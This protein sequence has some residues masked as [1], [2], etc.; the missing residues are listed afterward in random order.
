M[1]PSCFIIGEGTL[2]IECSTIL[3]QRG[4][5]IRGI[6]S[7]DPQVL[8]YCAS[9]GLRSIGSSL[10]VATILNDEPFDYLFSISNGH[11]L[12]EE[13]LNIPRLFTL[14]YHDGPLP[15]YA[16]V[17]ATFWAL[18]ND[19]KTH[20]VTWH[21]VDTGIDTGAIVK[22]KR[23]PIQSDETSISLNIK[24]YAAAVDAFR[25][26][27]DELESGKLTS[28]PQDTAGRSYYARNKRPDLILNFD[29]PAATIARM[30]RSLDFGFQSNPFGFL[31]IWA[32]NRFWLVRGA[33]AATTD[34]KQLPGTIEACFPDRLLIATRDFLLVIDDVQT[35]DGEPVSMAV[36]YEQTSLTEGQLVRLPAPELIQAINRAEMQ[37]AVHQAY[38]VDKLCQFQP[39]KLS[40]LLPTGKRDGTPPER[41]QISIPLCKPLGRRIGIESPT[42]YPLAMT[43]LLVTLARLTNQRSIGVG[44]RS[45]SS[46]RIAAETAGA[47]AEYLPLQVAF[48]WE[49]G[50]ERALYT[51]Q[52]ELVTLHNHLTFAQESLVSQTALQPLKQENDQP[53]FPILIDGN[54]PVSD[55][56]F[57]GDG[58]RISLPT[59]ENPAGQVS[60]D[61]ARWPANWVADLANRWIL[62][63]ENLVRQPSQPL[64]LVSLLT[65]DEQQRILIDWNATKTDYPTHQTV[66][67]LVEA[68]ADQRPQAEALRVGSLAL[69]YEQLNQ[70]ANQLAWHLQGQGIKPD[71]LLG[72][73]LERSADMIVS[74]LAILKVGGAYVPLDPTFPTARLAELVAETGLHHI[75]TQRAWVD[76]LP[77]QSTFIILDESRKLIARQSSCNLAISVRADQLAYVLFTSGSTGRSKGVAVPHRAIVRTVRSTNYMR[78]DETICMLGL[79]PL[80][81][82]A[83]TLEIWGSLANGGRLVMLSENPPSLDD[84]KQ[85]IQVHAVNAVFFTAAL[86]NVLVDSG[87]DGLHT[88]TQLATGGEAAS[89]E[90]V[91]RARRQLPHCTLINGYG[92]TE[93]TTFASFYNLTAGD[94]GTGPVPIGKPLS[95]TQL[96]IVDSFMNPMPVGVPGELLIGGMAWLGTT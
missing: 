94:W 33:R 50:F 74:L 49:T 88:L 68:Q 58:L 44:Y 23:F 18:V 62:L 63:L 21:L 64:R 95:N 43:A 69:T 90:H 8:T 6:I 37:C 15:A 46:A 14:N 34:A 93:S 84:I 55:T 82:D 7:Q 5:L 35:L 12:S 72:I 20:G 85:T 77:A 76:R 80:A 28:Y 75:I 10:P 83:S 92:P 26:V 36:F 59:E 52:Q 22:Q 57:P 27:L 81:F 38:W 24:C 86:F 9:A 32:G 89:A 25:E 39:T 65:P 41:Q 70:R 31:K 42:I 19:E 54:L 30:Q 17:H 56:S 29:Q 3:C 2:L 60:F 16:G 40:G 66:H 48:D 78:L 47:F 11:I 45:E 87:I 91:L 13:I 51:T 67:Q 73:C 4:F 79:A 96:Y 71:T 1:P 53:L 61:P